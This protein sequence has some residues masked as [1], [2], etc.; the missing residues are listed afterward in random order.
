MK[1]LCFNQECG[2]IFYSYLLTIPVTRKYI[3]KFP[4]TI[5]EQYMKT[6]S[7]PNWENFVKAKK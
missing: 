5:L 7:E 2:D 4:H 1:N 3:D 6:I